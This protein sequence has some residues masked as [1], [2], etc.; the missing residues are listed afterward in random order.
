VENSWKKGSTRL[1]LD[2]TNDMVVSGD[3][4][5]IKQITASQGIVKRDGDK[6]IVIPTTIGLLKITVVAESGTQEFDFTTEPLPAPTALKMG[7]TEHESD[8]ITTTGILNCNGLKIWNNDESSENLFSSFYIDKYNLTVFNQTYELTN[9][10]FSNELR[11]VLKVL[12]KGDKISTSTVTLSH[13]VT[14]KKLKLNI[15]KEY[16]IEE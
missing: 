10:D 1:Y 8:K 11:N 5:A 2:V 15:K 12:K 7:I 9:R 4:T 16:Q 14:G 6:L 3:I 13:K